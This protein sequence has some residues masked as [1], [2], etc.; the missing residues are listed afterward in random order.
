MA[1]KIKRNIKIF[2]MNIYFQGSCNK[3]SNALMHAAIK[4][5]VQ[6]GVVHAIDNAL[7]M[8]AQLKF[9]FSKK[10]IK[11]KTITLAHASKLSNLILS[12][13]LFIDLTLFRQ[14]AS[15]VISQ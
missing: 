3:I 12:I 10:V 7:M 9:K 15:G 5:N 1:P 13:P 8:I 2:H 11:M 14:S 4:D 6:L